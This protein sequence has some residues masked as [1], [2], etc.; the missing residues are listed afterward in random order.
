MEEQTRMLRMEETLADIQARLDRL[1]KTLDEI[2]QR[3]AAREAK[4]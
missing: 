4:R 3:L 1:Q 2:N